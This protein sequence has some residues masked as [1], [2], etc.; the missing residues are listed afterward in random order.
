MLINYVEGIKKTDS[1]LIEEKRLPLKKKTEKNRRIL[2][3]YV[4]IKFRIKKIS[5]EAYNF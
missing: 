4:L 5:I 1:D 2:V 3:S